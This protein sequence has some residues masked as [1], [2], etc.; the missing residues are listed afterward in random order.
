MAYLFTLLSRSA[1]AGSFTDASGELD[2]N[3][4]DVQKKGVYVLHI[5]TLQAVSVA[6]Q[7]F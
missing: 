5:G 4:V 2:F 7:S 6:L 3:V 1:F